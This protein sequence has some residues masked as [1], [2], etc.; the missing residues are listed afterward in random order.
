MRALWYLGPGRMELQPTPV[1]DPRP[2]EVVIKVGAAGVCGSDLHGYL[3]KS[4]NR[5]FP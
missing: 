4:L 1:P 3:G 2:N 5:N